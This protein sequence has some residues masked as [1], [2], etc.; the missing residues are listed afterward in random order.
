MKPASSTIF[1]L[2]P[3]CASMM[4]SRSLLWNMSRSISVLRCPVFLLTVWELMQRTA[5]WATERPATARLT[6]AAVRE[7]AMVE[8]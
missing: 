8:V 2:R 6:A 3:L 5:C 7:S 4:N 1:A